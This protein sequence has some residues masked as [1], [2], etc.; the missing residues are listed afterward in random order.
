MPQVGARSD[1]RFALTQSLDG[2]DEG[3]NGGLDP[4]RLALVGRFRTVAVI[5]VEHPQGRDCGAERIHRVR[6]GRE[7]VQQVQDVFRQRGVCGQFRPKRLQLHC[8]GQ[9]AI[10]Q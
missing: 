5:G 10:P 2:G 4:Q 8:R 6:R 7:T 1:R 3:A 9:R